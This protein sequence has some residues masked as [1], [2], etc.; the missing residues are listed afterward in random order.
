MTTTT[1]THEHA[2][3]MPEDHEHDVCRC[4]CGAITAGEVWSETETTRY[5]VTVTHPRG[6]TDDERLQVDGDAIAAAIECGSFLDDAPEGTE[7]S[8]HLHEADFP[9]TPP[10]V[11][12]ET[13]RPKCPNPDCGADFEEFQNVADV[14]DIRGADEYEPDRWVFDGHADY[15]DADRGWVECRSCLTR[16]AVPDGVELDWSH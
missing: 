11:D 9:G 5:V 10:A 1:T 2:C 4:T 8:V 3:A 14:A 15:T 12:E 16:I 13:G 7:F 6:I